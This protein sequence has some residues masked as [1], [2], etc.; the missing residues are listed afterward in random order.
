[1]KQKAAAVAAND[2]QQQYV[3]NEAKSS[4]KQQQTPT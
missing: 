1:M 4:E 3:A 2:I